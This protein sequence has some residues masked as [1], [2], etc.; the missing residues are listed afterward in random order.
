[1]KTD[2]CAQQIANWPTATLESIC[3]RVTSGGT[4]RRLTSGYYTGPGGI[5]WVKTQELQD[6]LLQDTEEHITELALTNS[7]AKRLPKG[8]LLMA[9]YAAP[10]AGRMAIL[11]KEMACNQAACAF[12]FDARK[13]DVQYMFYQLLHARPDLHR[14]ANGAAQQNLSARVLKALEVVLPPL[15]EQRRIARVLV[16]LDELIAS[17]QALAENCEAL[18]QTLTATA[19]SHAPLASFATSRGL[20]TLAP[21]GDVEHYSL[22]AFDNGR[23]PER[24][25]GST[26][27]S[28]KQKIEHACVLVSRLNPH[29]PRVWM[30]YPDASL[31]SLASTEFVPIAGNGVPVELVYSVCSA[32]SYLEQMKALVTG[33]TGSHQR[34]DREALTRVSV[35]DVRLLPAST[36]VAIVALVQQAA[37][38]RAEMRRLAATRDE[39]IPLVMSGRIR[40]EDVAA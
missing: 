23:T 40:V 10:T 13:A 20:P 12:V 6:K 27:K 3:T 17:N 22:P 31:T 21:S 39:L 38:S 25:D 35:P 7:S 15:E 4:P 1:M 19:V 11:G 36:S 8:T 18:A 2:L 33:T 34:V 26:I 32:P 14:L 30:V 24:A 5:P 9:M 37:S 16:A 29:I 28:N